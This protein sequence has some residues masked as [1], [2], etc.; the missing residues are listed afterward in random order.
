MLCG[1]RRAA[2][3]DA[4]AFAVHT[5]KAGFERDAADLTLYQRGPFSEHFQIR[6]VRQRPRIAGTEQRRGNAQLDLIGG[7]V[8]DMAEVVPRRRRLQPAL[9]AAS[10]SAGNIIFR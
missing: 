4:A 3:K 5:N 2:E 7:G 8:P 9:E 6:L 1:R 10:G